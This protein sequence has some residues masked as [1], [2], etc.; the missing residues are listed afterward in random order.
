MTLA[1]S[2]CRWRRPVRRR[3]REV[4]RGLLLAEDLQAWLALLPDTAQDA[5]S[6]LE[7]QQ[8]RRMR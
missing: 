1:S 3:H 6:W 2:F 4:P 7:I 5:E 8:N